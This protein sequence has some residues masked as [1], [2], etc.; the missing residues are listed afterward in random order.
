[1]APTPAD[2]EA[3]VP[4][5]ASS[6]NLSNAPIGGGSVEESLVIAA[7]T[8]ADEGNADGG[9][10]TSFQNV[11]EQYGIFI[12]VSIGA[13]VF[14]IAAVYAVRSYQQRNASIQS[15]RRSSYGYD[16]DGGSY[17]RSRVSFYN[18]YY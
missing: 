11:M 16:D 2:A 17:S 14:F 4:A 3:I 6:P 7:S 8:G 9:G 13:I 18:D 15:R 10:S 1:V 12:Y 5:V